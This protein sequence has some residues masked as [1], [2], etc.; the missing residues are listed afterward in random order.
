M[1][2]NSGARQNSWV[3]RVKGFGVSF[4]HHPKK[5]TLW[6]TQKTQTLVEFTLKHKT[7]S[8]LLTLQKWLV[9]LQNNVVILH[10]FFEGQKETQVVSMSHVATTPWIRT[11]TFGFFARSRLLA[12][13]SCPG[14]VRLSFTRKPDV[15]GTHNGGPPVDLSVA[16]WA[17]ILS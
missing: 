16:I 4:E 10:P 11:P 13:R 3:W 7:W 14:V 12:A 15:S 1:T 6:Y 2:L 5:G 9:I 8:L 17:P